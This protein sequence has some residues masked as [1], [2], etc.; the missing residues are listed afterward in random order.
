MW[1]R[2]SDRCWGH[3]Q[4]PPFCFRVGSAPLRRP[5]RTA[6]C[7]GTG[8]GGACGDRAGAAEGRGTVGQRQRGRAG[9]AVGRGLR[10]W[11]LRGRG[12]GGPVGSRWILMWF[13]SVRWGLS[14]FLLGSWGIPMGSRCVRWVP[15]GSLWVPVGSRWFPLRSEGARWVPGGVLTGLFGIAVGFGAPGGVAVCPTVKLVC[16]VGSRRVPVG[17][18]VGPNEVPAFPAVQ[19]VSQWFP[20]WCWWGSVESWWVPMCPVGSQ[21]LLVGFWRFLLKCR[22]AR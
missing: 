22:C 4:S 12:R 15:V 20:L 13:C 1:P 3:F 17:V 21:W 6:R 5:L 16:P 14:E 10:W 19:V 11:E 2:G 18:S 9:S 7:A 8:L